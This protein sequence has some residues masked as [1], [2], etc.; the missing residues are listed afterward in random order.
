[1]SLTVGCGVML[2]LQLIGSSVNLPLGRRPHGGSGEAFFLRGRQRPASESADGRR[3]TC[4]ANQ[5]A[6]SCGYGHSRRPAVPGRCRP[7]PRR[8]PLWDVHSELDH[9][10]AADTRPGRGSNAAVAALR[11]AFPGPDQSAGGVNGPGSDGRSTEATSRSGWSWAMV[12][13]I[14][15]LSRAPPTELMEPAIPASSSA[16]RT[17]ATCIAN[18]YR[19]GAPGRSLWRRRCGA[20]VLGAGPQPLSGGICPAQPPVRRLCTSRARRAAAASVERP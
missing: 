20:S 2:S 7:C 4:P 13:F 5:S 14:S 17:P 8:S 19:S 16:R 18:R 12:D 9:S 3:A 6:G 15:A 10:L 11:P 1:L